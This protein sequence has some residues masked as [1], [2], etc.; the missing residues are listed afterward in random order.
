MIGSVKTQIVVDNNV[1][2]QVSTFKYIEYDSMY[3]VCMWPMYNENNS[4][5]LGAGVV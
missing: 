4:V 3:N 2:E 5:L 1:I